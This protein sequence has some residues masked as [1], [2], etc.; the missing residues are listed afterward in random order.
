M[1]EQQDAPFTIGEAS[2]RTGLPESTIRF[3][4]REFSD[5]LSIGRGDNNQRQFSEANLED[6]EYIRYL[7][8]REDLSVEEVSE[9]LEREQDFKNRQD[10]LEGEDESTSA[11]PDQVDELRDSVDNLKQEISQLRSLLTDQGE[12]IDSVRE[13]Q[14]D[15][16][17]LL[18]MNLQRYNKLV[19]EM[20]T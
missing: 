15:I 17:K 6:L 12:A 18:D 16:L 7:I 3:Y 5:Y 8:K 10:N 11:P 19:D 20:T 9:R 1:S 13:D 14:E 4:D 2:E